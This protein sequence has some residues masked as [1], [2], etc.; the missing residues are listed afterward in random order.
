MSMGNTNGSLY[1]MPAAMVS[2]GD[3][4]PN[5]AAVTSILPTLG[6]TG[7]AAR[8]LPRGVSSSV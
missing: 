2:A 3:K 5:V 6:S 1:A 8:C 7:S 4:H